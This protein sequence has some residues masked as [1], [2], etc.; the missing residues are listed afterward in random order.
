MG[1]FTP[2]CMWAP[3]EIGGTMAWNPYLFKEDG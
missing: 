1:E 2:L 3:R